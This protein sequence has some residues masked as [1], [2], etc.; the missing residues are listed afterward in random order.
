[1]PHE[2]RLVVAPPRRLVRFAAVA[3]FAPNAGRAFH[4]QAPATRHLMAGKPEPP[5]ELPEACIDEAPAII[6][7]D[8][9]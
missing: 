2:A 4:A 5:R 7:R 6:E 8:G 3:R 9:V 1:M